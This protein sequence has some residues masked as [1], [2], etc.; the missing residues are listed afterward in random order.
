MI[1]LSFD[2]RY[3]TCGVRLLLLVLVRAE[4]DAGNGKTDVTATD[5]FSNRLCGIAE[6][7]DND[8]SSD[9]RSRH[10][11]KRPTWHLRKSRTTNGL[12]LHQ[13]QK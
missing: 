9:A 4:K 6:S 7:P 5:D 1:Q 2:K 13:H 11:I 3:K 10:E 8:M 12:Q